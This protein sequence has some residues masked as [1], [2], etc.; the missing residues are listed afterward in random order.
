MSYR[1]EQTSVKLEEPIRTETTGQFEEITSTFKDTTGKFE[2]ITGRF[3]E[4]ND[5]FEE[6]PGKLSR[7]WRR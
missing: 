1:F 3:V 7:H 2:E 6:T 5:K 4:K